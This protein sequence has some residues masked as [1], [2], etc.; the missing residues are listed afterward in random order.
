MIDYYHNNKKKFNDIILSTE[1]IAPGMKSLISDNSGSDINDDDVSNDGKV[2]SCKT[3]WNT[4]IVV[5]EQPSYNNNQFVAALSVIANP[6][7]NNNQLVA[8]R[9]VV[10]NPN[11]RRGFCIHPLCIGEGFS[12]VQKG[13][14]CG[15][16]G[17]DFGVYSNFNY[18][19]FEGT[20]KRRVKIGTFCVQHGGP[21]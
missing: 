12:K 18:C 1:T 3:D 7:V 14:Y 2:L 19:N 21:A 20:C 17:P 4:G 11:D 6:N 16:C 9:P 8:A 10:A 13:E 15:P 5:L